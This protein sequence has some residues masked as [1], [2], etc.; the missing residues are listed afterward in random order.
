[1]AASINANHHVV[2]GKVSPA[3]GSHY[4]G[5][6]GTDMFTI[7]QL[8]LYL[9]QGVKSFPRF[10]IFPACPPELAAKSLQVFGT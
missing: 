6:G 5:P 3:K 9:R 4:G 10:D 1:M 8:N 2:D 7:I